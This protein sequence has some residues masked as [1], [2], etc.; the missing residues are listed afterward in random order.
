MCIRDRFNWGVLLGSSAMLGVPCWDVVLPLYAAGICWT[1]VYDTI[2]AL[3]DI[4]DDKKVKNICYIFLIYCNAKPC[5]I[6]LANHSLA[7]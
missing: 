1:L 7:L 6:D 3:Q 4:S 2:Y 5:F